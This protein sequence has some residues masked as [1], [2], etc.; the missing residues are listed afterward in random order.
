MNNNAWCLVQ[1]VLNIVGFSS[2]ACWLTFLVLALHLDIVWDSK[3]LE[4]HMYTM[5]I[6]G[7]GIA[8][9]AT[10]VAAAGNAIRYVSGESCFVAREYMSGLFL[11]P[12]AVLMVPAVVLFLLTIIYLI[13]CFIKS[14]RQR[15]PSAGSVSHCCVIKSN[16]DICIRNNWRSLIFTSCAMITYVMF[17]FYNFAFRT[18]NFNDYNTSISYSISCLLQ[19]MSTDMCLGLTQPLLPSLALTFISESSV[20][21]LGI[22]L[23]ILYGIEPQLISD[24]K[25]KL[26][27]KNCNSQPLQPQQRQQGSVMP[28]RGPVR[29]ATSNSEKSSAIQELPSRATESADQT[30]VQSNVG[31]MHQAY[32]HINNHYRQYRDRSHE[33]GA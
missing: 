21:V 10:I 16:L 5:H 29:V 15:R 22:L 11:Y 8:V 2:L 7:W 1:G 3:R 25:F 9:V 24:W 12:T 31:T 28:S 6:I 19:G 14:R 18:Q 27:G 32:Q 4:R 30:L 23:C 20:A 26:C 17:W 13:W 33:Y